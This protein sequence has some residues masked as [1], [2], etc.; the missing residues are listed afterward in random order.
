MTDRPFTFKVRPSKF[1]QPQPAISPVTRKQAGPVVPSTPLAPP[2]TSFAALHGALFGLP[3]LFMPPEPALVDPE[4]P[5]LFM[6]A[7]GLAP[8]LVLGAPELPFGAAE[9]PLAVPDPPLGAS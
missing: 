3:G 8:P 7:A 4:M 2:V 6:P 1:E 5:T 9:P